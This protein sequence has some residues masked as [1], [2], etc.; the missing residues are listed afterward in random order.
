ME[1][2]DHALF[3]R[4][5]ADATASA[6]GAT[7][8][9]VLADLGWLDAFDDDPR[10]AVSILFE[11][12][13]SANVTSRA[14]DQ[15]LVR[16]LGFGDD[17]VG[18]T[19]R[20]GLVVVLPPL[21][22]IEAPGTIIDGRCTVGGVALSE[23]ASAPTAVVVSPVAGGHHALAV[24]VGSLALRRVGGLD[25]RLGLVEVSGVVDVGSTTRLGPVRWEDAMALGQLALGYELVGS[26]RTMV[27]LARRHA[28]DRVQFGRTI[29]GFQAVRHRLADSLVAAEAAAALLDAAWD[30]PAAYGAMAKSFAGRQGRMVARHCQQVLAGIGFTAE[31]PFHHLVRRTL[32]LDQLLGAGTVLTRRLGTRILESATLPRAFPL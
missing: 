14:L 23:L 16:A 13:G 30:D 10:A 26:A 6:T 1:E 8:D 4:G 12:Q 29:S 22:E 3:A 21:R 28:L 2:A 24:P 5:I 31:H 25:P 7:L 27:E 17:A 19:A 18:L 9:S 15:V 11:S 32:V 20:G